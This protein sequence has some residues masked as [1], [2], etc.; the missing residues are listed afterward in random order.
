MSQNDKTPSQSSFAPDSDSLDAVHIPAKSLYGLTPKVEAAILDA[1]DAG[2]QARIKA[3]TAPLHS[4]DMAD[5]LERV[6][7]DMCR[8]LLMML[9]DELDSEVI[10]YLDEDTRELVL[11]IMG[12]QAIARALP[13]LESDDA[14]TIAE[15]LE[16]EELD[17]V[18][19]NLP[20]QER[21]IVEQGLSYPEDSAGRMMQREMV[22]LPPYWTVG[23][24]I[25]HLRSI[26]GPEQEDFYIIMVVDT[27]GHPVGEINLGR[28]LRAN[29]PVRLSEIMNTDFRSV[30]V[31]MDQEE[32]AMLFRRYGMVTTS[33]VDEDGRLLG[34]ITLDDIVDVIDEE[35][36]EDLMALAGVSDASIRSSMLETLQGRASWLFVNLL[37]AVLAS[38]VIGLFE[39][40]LEQIVALAVLMPIVASM[41]GN[42]GTQTVTVAVRAIAMQEFNSDSAMR[43][44]LR[45]VAVAAV[46]GVLFAIVAG[47]VAYLWFG[48]LAIAFI[49]GG[50]MIVNLIIAGLTGTLVPLSLVRVGVDP[51]VASSVFITTITDVVGFFVF[52][53]LA[54][55]FLL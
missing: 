43:F 22:M 25:D 19:K 50:A 7:P 16:P 14:L 39:T 12:P 31:N 29:R 49:L 47:A 36:E 45:E 13:E 8:Q 23:Q 51:A 53:G 48:D 26:G 6:R 28:L 52:L 46:N 38:L 20:A 40:T 30:P 9:G 37:T 54:A 21:V 10:A 41:G 4:A 44:A 33:V 34:V 27:A 15:E 55:Y 17:E 32:V 35:A 3:L 5:L 42:A 1:L 11:D 24:T 2:E 18:L